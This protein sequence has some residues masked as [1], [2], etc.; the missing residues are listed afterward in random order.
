MDV[1]LNSIVLPMGLGYS[2]SQ[3]IRSAQSATNPSP[4]I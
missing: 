1:V 3:R 4:P 2:R